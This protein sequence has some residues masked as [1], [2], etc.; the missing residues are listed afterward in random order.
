M[1]NSFCIVRN[2]EAYLSQHIGELTGA[3]SFAFYRESI[4]HLSSVLTV[5]PQRCACDLHPDYLS[6]RFARSRD[7]PCRAV[8]HHHAHIGAVLAEHGLDGPVLGV[9]LDGAGF[10]PDS[11][12]FGGEIYRADRSGFVRLGR[13]SHLLLP[14]GDRAAREP[15]RMALAL[16]YQGLGQAAFAKASRVP[17]LAAIAADKQNVLAQMLVKEL[18]CPRSSSC[19]RLFDG[20]AALTGLCLSSDYEG[21]AAMLL[22]ARAA[23]VPSSPAPASLSDHLPRG[24]RGV[25]DR[26]G[27]FGRPHPARTLPRRSMSQLLPVVFTCGWWSLW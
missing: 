22:E 24:E 4:E 3:E 2:Q 18:N 19:G 1:K 17:A 15:W 5:T 7:L 25:V 23:G 8:Q 27:A 20:V 26:F 10:G 14:G 16:L 13:L 6:T 11:T 9:V 12:V 21:Q